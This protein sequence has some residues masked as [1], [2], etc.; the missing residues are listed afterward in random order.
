M[1]DDRDRPDTTKS[2]L[3][4]RYSELPTKDADQWGQ[5]FDEV[6]GRFEKLVDQWAGKTLNF[7]ILANAGALLLVLNQSAEFLRANRPIE[8]LIVAAAVFCLGLILAGWAA[9]VSYRD[10]NKKHAAIVDL[11]ENF[12]AD[13]ITLGDFLKDGNPRMGI[14]IAMRRLFLAAFAS[15][16]IGVGVGFWSL[17]QAAFAPSPVETMPAKQPMQPP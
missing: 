17:Q 1:P 11:A 16:V 6:N 3:E 2:V 5:Q 10:I 7:L 13:R 12:T 4:L 8:G 15:F 9:Y 14:D